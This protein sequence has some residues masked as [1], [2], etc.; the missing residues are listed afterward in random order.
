M[1]SLVLEEITVY[2]YLLPEQVAQL[3][4]EQLLQDDEPPE[5]PPSLLDLL[6]PTGAKTLTIFLLPHFSHF[7]WKLFSPLIT[8]SETHP[9]SLHL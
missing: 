6:K 5:S 8:T 7:I 3:P 4:P 2:S 1:K 9:Q